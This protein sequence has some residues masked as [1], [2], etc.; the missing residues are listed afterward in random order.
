MAPDT[1]E[2]SV[3]S[4][5]GLVLTELLPFGG[6]HLDDAIVTHMKRKFNLLIGRKTACQLKE[7][8]GSAVPGKE[9]SM[10]V[11]GRDVVSGLPIEMEVLASTVY[12]GMKSELESLCNSIKMILESSTGT[13]KRY[14]IF[15]NLFNRRQC[16]HC[17]FGRIV[18]RSDKY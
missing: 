11:V 15:R 12:D 18:H 4:L 17:R 7:N 9:A 3:I 10:T 8:I 16:S 5:G 6:N 13:C 1:T 2:I 14:C